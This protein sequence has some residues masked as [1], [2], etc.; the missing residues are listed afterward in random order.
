M[1]HVINGETICA[2]THD[3]TIE[4]IVI[5]PRCTS[6]REPST[7]QTEQGGDI[8]HFGGC[9]SRPITA[10][11]LS[12]TWTCQALQDSVSSRSGK[13]P[14]IITTVDDPLTFPPPRSGPASH[15]HVGSISTAYRALGRRR[16]S[17]CCQ[18]DSFGTTPGR[19]ISAHSSLELPQPRPRPIR[20]A[21][22]LSY[23]H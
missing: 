4:E 18:Q 1:V 11:V 21:K 20:L 7:S 10:A 6:T 3:T 14:S 12:L 16:G 19:P 17:Q 5:P 13:S 23:L 8:M 15:N 22:R 9:G 2:R